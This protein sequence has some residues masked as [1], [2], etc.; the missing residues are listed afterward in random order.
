MLRDVDDIALSIDFSKV[1]QMSVQ[2]RWN[3]L[4]ELLARAVKRRVMEE[5]RNAD[6]E[7]DK[8]SE[9]RRVL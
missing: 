8:K 4:V 6:S 1:D 5:E 3:I 2:E 7:R 9:V